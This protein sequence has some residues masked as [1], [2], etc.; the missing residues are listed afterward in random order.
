M[1]SRVAAASSMSSV[2]QK[3][4][5]TSVRPSSGSLK[6][7]DPGTGATPISAVSQWLNAV[8]SLS[9]RSEKSVRM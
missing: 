3:A 5:R 1:L 8:S 6:K 4:N 9:E 2:L 7:L